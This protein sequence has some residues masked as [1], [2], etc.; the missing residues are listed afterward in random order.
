MIPR[1]IRNNNPGNIR[2]ST[3]PWVG[4]TGQDDDGFCVFSTAHYGIRALAKLLLTYHD[5]YGLCTITT[6]IDRWAPPNENDTGAYVDSV[7]RA[8]GFGANDWLHLGEVSV[9]SALVAAIIRH[10]NGEQPYS[11]AEVLAGVAAAMP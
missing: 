8:T 3:I 2:A 6:I 7:C 9:L 5:R 4:Q 11:D 1:G 10:E